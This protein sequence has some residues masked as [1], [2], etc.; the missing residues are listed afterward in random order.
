MAATSKEGSRR[1]NC[2]ISTRGGSDK[3]YR[4]GGPC[5]FRAWHED[6]T[7]TLPSIHWRASSGAS[8]R[9]NSCSNSVY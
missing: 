4:P 5:A 1:A 7:N 2:P 3:K 8:S 6:S 9:G